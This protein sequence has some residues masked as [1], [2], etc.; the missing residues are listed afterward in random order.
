[1]TTETLTPEELKIHER[2]V[3]RYKEAQALV[4]QAQELQQRANHLASGFAVWAE[5]LHERYGLDAAK[6]E[7]VQEDG[8]IV[9]ARPKPPP[10]RRRR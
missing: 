7:G 4:A 3:A 10:K 5:D 6:G 1:M 9:R 8:T 2:M